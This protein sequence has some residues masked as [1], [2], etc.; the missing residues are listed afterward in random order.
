[1]DFSFL[2]RG[3]GA[4]STAS[5]TAA[6]AFVDAKAETAQPPSTFRS[7]FAAARTG[8]PVVSA[9]P[10][11]GA[12]A[13]SSRASKGSSSATS[14]ASS[15]SSF[16]APAAAS[17]RN[18]GSFSDVFSFVTTSAL[19]S[20]PVSTLPLPVPPVAYVIYLLYVYVFLSVPLSC[21]ALLGAFRLQRSFR[22]RVQ[23]GR[24]TAKTPRAF[25]ARDE[26]TVYAT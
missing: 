3:T 18:D 9:L 25:G 8:P 26:C 7:S 23:S 14:T 13:A 2:R 17:A 1:M 19:Y 21:R 15:A 11:S 22:T 5:N 20:A 12:P 24:S 16:L 10:A 6:A 4:A